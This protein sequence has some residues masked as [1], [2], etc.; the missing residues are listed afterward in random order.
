MQQEFPAVGGRLSVRHHFLQQLHPYLLLGNR[1]ALE[2]LFEF[3]DVLVAVKSNATAF[4]T[5]TARP[6]RLLVIAFQGLGHVVVDD[7]AHVGLVNAHAKRN[8]RD[9]HI[10]VLHQELVLDAA[11]LSTVHPR[12]VRQGFDAIDAERLSNLLYLLA[13]QAIDDA[14]LARIL[15]AMPD[16]LF[17]GILFGSDLIEQI[18]AVERRFQHNRIHH[19]QVFLDVLLDLGS[20][21]RRQRHDG[22]V[23]DAFD[24]RLDSS[25]FRSEVVAPF[26]DA[27]GFIHRHKTDSHRLQEFD[28][29]CFGQ[30]L[31]RHIEQL[32]PTFS[33][34]HFHALRFG[35]GQ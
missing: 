22:H 8:G 14:T 30:A 9:N 13:A 10:H 20:G 18:V 6:S 21:G 26:R 28:V 7:I 16:N 17:E 23:G 31:R 35:T 34:V 1:L 32:G 33:H 5:V 27:M 29:F 24:D 15:K 25:V 3:V 19:V 11:P 2:E 4:P 12:V